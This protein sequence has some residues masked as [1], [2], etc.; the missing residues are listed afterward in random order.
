MQNGVDPMT[1]VLTFFFLYNLRL[2]SIYSSYNIFIMA[3]S[4]HTERQNVK[5]K[6]IPKMSKNDVT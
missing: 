6:K 4:G 2:S 5:K 1:K 3:T